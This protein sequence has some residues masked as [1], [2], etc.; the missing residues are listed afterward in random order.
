MKPRVLALLSGLAL[1][2]A[3]TGASDV[4]TALPFLVVGAFGLS[5]AALAL[6]FAL[7][8]HRC[9]C[10]ILVACGVVLGTML[11]RSAPRASGAV[12]THA[13][14]GSRRGDLFE[15]LEQIDADPRA[16]LGRRVTVSGEWSRADGI[17]TEAVSRRIMACC[18]ADAVRVG[19]DVIP[20]HEQQLPADARV[21]VTGVLRS[22]LLDGDLRYVII[23]AH[24]EVIRC[25]PPCALP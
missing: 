2:A 24:V 7:A 22:R 1:S 5:G 10:A 25:A 16:L 21:R 18:A 8:R 13:V 23:A 12:V 11:P 15:L 9:T 14:S 3:A 6:A 17:H 4:L 20:S 19:F